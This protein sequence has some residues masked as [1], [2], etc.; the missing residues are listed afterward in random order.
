MFYTLLCFILCCVLFPTGT[1]C[2][3]KSRKNQKSKKQCYF[4]KCF[5]PRIIM[6]W[7]VY[8]SYSFLFLYREECSIVTNYTQVKSSLYSYRI[9]KVCIFFSFFC[10]QLIHNPI[11]VHPLLMSMC[12]KAKPHSLEQL[13]LYFNC[14]LIVGLCGHKEPKERVSLSFPTWYTLGLARYCK[15][16]VLLSFVRFYV[17]CFVPS[18]Y[19]TPER[20]CYDVVFS[21]MTSFQRPRITNV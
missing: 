20:R 12:N 16:C 14:Y 3:K 8:S 17:F 5:T 9:T 13:L 11:V 19:T 2:F 18:R 21:V 7:S 6:Y 4:F 15:V 1:L 10:L